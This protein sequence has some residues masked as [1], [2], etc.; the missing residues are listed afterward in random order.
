MACQTT[1]PPV[2]SST[3]DLKKEISDL[4]QQMEKNEYENQ[5]EI[6]R[7]KKANDLLAESLKDE[8]QKN[9]IVINRYRDILTIKI[10]EE[11][12]FDSGSAEIKK[13][14]FNVLNRIGKIMIN[15]PDKM[16][17][18]EG[19]TDNVP[20]AAGY[21]HVF[22]NNWALGATRAINVAEYFVKDLKFDP[23]RLEVASFSMY[24]PL[25]PNTSAVNRAKN[26]RI[27]IVLIN[28]NMYLYQTTG[29]KEY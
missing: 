17:K 25:V 1:Y 22:P 6:E 16:I 24:R 18:I 13:S 2:T 10:S 27:E 20:I 4:K 9:Q 21:K 8:I 19:H 7:T 14:G 15:F 26:R 23:K 11:I 3:E 28:K 29:V 5:Q 12:F